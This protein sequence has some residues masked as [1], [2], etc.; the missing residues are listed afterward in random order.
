MWT[1]E[2]TLLVETLWRQGLS[3]S[4]IAKKLGAVTRNAVIGK[5]HRLGIAKRDMPSTPRIRTKPAQRRVYAKKPALVVYSEPPEDMG[6]ETILTLG[7]HMCRWPIGIGPYTYCGAH[8]DK[9]YCG[10][11][12]ALGHVAKKHAA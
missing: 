9:T 3:A 1:D 12:H 10:Y 4:Q 6:K 11:H 7:A 5:V 8:T 2:R